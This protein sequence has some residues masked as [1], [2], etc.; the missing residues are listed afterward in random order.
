M[1]GREEDRSSDWEEIGKA[2]KAGGMGREVVSE[3]I[4]GSGCRGG[5]MK[6]VKGIFFPV[7]EHFERVSEPFCF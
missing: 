3:Q 2:V 6:A 5:V 7:I 1:E 4:E